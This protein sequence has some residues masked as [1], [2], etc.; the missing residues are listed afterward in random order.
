MQLAAMRER[1]HVRGPG[2]PFHLLVPTRLYWYACALDLCHFLL[3]LD[4][5]FCAGNVCQT[6]IFACASFP[7]MN[8]ALCLEAVTTYSCACLSGTFGP[9]RS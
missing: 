6:E 7:C 2:K 9:Q 8:G 5:A 1:R 3:D 4:A